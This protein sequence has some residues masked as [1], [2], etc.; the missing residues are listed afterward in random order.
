MLARAP[1]RRGAAT[2]LLGA[3]GG[4]GARRTG[5][6]AGGAPGQAHPGQPRRDTRRRRRRDGRSAGSLPP[7]PAPAASSRP[8]APSFFPGSNR[9]L[10]PVPRPRRLLFPSSP[11]TVLPRARL[12]APRQAPAETPRLSNSRTPGGIARG[13]TAPGILRSRGCRGPEER[14]EGQSREKRV[15]CIDS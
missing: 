1:A 10:P 3:P 11:P 12:G 6:A 9:H 13:K 15:S 7:R 8:P 5:A 14:P 4:P 2:H